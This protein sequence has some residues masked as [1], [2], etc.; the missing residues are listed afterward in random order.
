LRVGI[1]P[2]DI[3][4]YDIA[5]YDIAPYD[6]AP[7]DIAPYDIAPYDIAPYEYKTKLGSY[8]IISRIIPNRDGSIPLYHHY[9]SS[10]ICLFNN[11]HSQY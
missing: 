2:Y 5:P 9:G 8:I 6:I 11:Y 10:F 4:P 3:A 7:Y 1:A